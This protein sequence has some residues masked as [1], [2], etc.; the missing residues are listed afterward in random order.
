MGVTLL[1]L[2]V[3]AS[4]MHFF[5]L[6]PLKMSDGSLSCYHIWSACLFFRVFFSLVPFCPSASFPVT[7]LPASVS[8]CAFHC[9]FTVLLRT[10]AFD[11]D[12]SSGTGRHHKDGNRSKYMM[13]VHARNDWNGYSVSLY[14]ML[15]SN[16]PLLSSLLNT[17]DVTC[18]FQFISLLRIHGFDLELLQVS[19]KVRDVNACTKTIVKVKV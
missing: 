10:N 14:L 9:I 11:P 16:C 13:W 18:F 5:K 1:K 12:L 8:T 4:D 2:S 19:I 17:F 15:C 6:A 3:K 7:L